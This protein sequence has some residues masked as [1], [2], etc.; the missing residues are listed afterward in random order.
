MDIY[1]GRRKQRDDESAIY[2][3]RICSDAPSRWSSP[4]TVHGDTGLGSIATSRVVAQSREGT[5]VLQR[6]LPRHVVDS[7]QHS[8]RAATSTPTPA[9]SSDRQD[10]PGSSCSA[11]ASGRCPA[12]RR[13]TCACWH[14]TRNCLRMLR[15]PVGFPAR[16][17]AYRTR[18]SPSR[19]AQRAPGRG[20][21]S[22]RPASRSAPWRRG[23]H[24]R[25]RSA[26]LLW[27]GFALLCFAFRPRMRRRE[28]EWTCEKVLARTF[29]G[30]ASAAAAPKSGR[31]R[32]V[33]PGVTGRHWTVLPPTTTVLPA[34]LPRFKN[35]RGSGPS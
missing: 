10:S 11:S 1:C 19:S 15:N 6:R 34:A 7:S 12:H 21:A 26:F 3:M 23:A 20:S 33:P 29:R 14:W 16:V 8:A 5:Q 13:P 18:R 32:D 17:A 30:P 22:P 25:V 2:L 24:G 35:A 9:G 28:G 27:P 4:P 31:P